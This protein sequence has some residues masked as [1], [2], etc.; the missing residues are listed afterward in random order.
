M[1]KLSVLFVLALGM[2][3]TVYSQEGTTSKSIGICFSNLNSFGIRYKV[4]NDKSM[5]RIT[6]LSLSAGHSDYDYASGTTTKRGAAGFALN[7]GVECPV[8]TID[9]FS[10]YCG[11][12]LQG[13]FHHSKT[14]QTG[15][16]DTKTSTY[17]TGAGFVAGFSYR[18]KSNI[19]LAAEL[20]PA[21][22]YTYSKTGDNTYKVW[23][24]EMNNN[25]AAIIVS[26]NF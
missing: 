5:F 1:K 14:E 23:S 12:E 24:F 25:T 13:S 10:F 11:G 19:S 6:A 21:L 26:Y 20:V 9:Q 18:F 16:D 8:K 3:G 4:G 22:D 2:L 7:F 17:E 15:S